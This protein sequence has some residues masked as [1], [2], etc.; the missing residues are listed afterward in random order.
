MKTSLS[1]SCQWRASYSFSEGAIASLIT[2][3]SLV[4][5][6]SH[7]PAVIWYQLVNDPALAQNQT[8]AEP[9][10]SG[11]FVIKVPKENGKFIS[12]T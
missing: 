11:D 12:R 3:Y 4:R 6:V 10:V 1:I 5:E 8:G 7:H 2:G 9:V